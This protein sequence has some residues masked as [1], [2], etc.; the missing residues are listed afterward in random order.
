M[1]LASHVV[2]DR[3][4]LTP[5]EQLDGFTTLAIYGTYLRDER[6]LGRCPNAG[7][8]HRAVVDSNVF[9]VYNQSDS[10]E[11]A[12][13][14][15][16]DPRCPWMAFDFPKWARLD[17]A[18][19]VALRERGLICPEHGQRLK[20]KVLKARNVPTIKCTGHCQNA[21]SDKCECECGGKRHGEAWIR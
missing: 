16:G 2:G 17:V 4:M 8:R 6:L 14:A 1:I 5:P 15:T 7:C 10:W 9:R 18:T 13:L 21:I 11:S 12:R 3:V 20:L 19:L